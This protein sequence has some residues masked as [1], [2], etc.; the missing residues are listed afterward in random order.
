MKT[1]LD[2]LPCY[3]RQA[4]YAARLSTDDP[5]IRQRIMQQAA[6]LLPTLDL[7]LSPPE[8]SMPLYRLIAEL[9]GCLDPFA[10][11]KKKS[12]TYALQ[13][14]PHLREVI[15][16]ARDP[17][18][19]A[20]KFAIAGN[21][22]DYG[23]HHD[24]DADLAMQACLQQQLAVND[25]ERL[26]VDLEQAGN[27]L[28]LG[29]NCGELVFDGLLIDLL[30]NTG[31]PGKKIT[32]AVKDQAIINDALLADAI[33]CGLDRSCEIISNGT[34]CPGTP[35]A[36]CSSSFLQVFSEADLIISKGQGNYETLSESTA[37][38]YFLLTVKCPVV[39]SCLVKRSG[40][41][42]A[43]SGNNEMVLMKNHNGLTP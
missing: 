38:L 16:E 33:A 10:G 13:L 28:Y 34:A 5:D 3:M 25:F 22:I 27:I 9:S 6:L 43:L 31:R 11:L 30:A 41:T 1:T 40:T 35:L 14:R 24:F 32:L 18:L 19:T 20:I 7:S 17:L 4:L 23:A 12:N 21:I 29:D 39:G 8:N 2:C 42:A 37:P 15:K 36:I 26:R